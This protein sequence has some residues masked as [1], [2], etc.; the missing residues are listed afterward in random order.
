[1][2]APNIDSN[3]YALSSTEDVE[4]IVNELYLQLC[5]RSLTSHEIWELKDEVL[6]AQAVLRSRRQ[7]NT[8]RRPCVF[9]LLPV[10]D[11]DDGQAHPSRKAD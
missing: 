8:R 2:T 11:N 10:A 6:K 9:S 5:D 7:A 3:P 1:M 4:T